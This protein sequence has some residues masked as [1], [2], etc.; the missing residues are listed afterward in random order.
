MRAKFQTQY[1]TYMSVYCRAQHIS[2]LF[3]SPPAEFAVVAGFFP[4]HFSAF[5]SFSSS[6][7]AFNHETLYPFDPIERKST[8]NCVSNSFTPLFVRSSCSILL[9]RWYD[10]RYLFETFSMTPVFQTA[11]SLFTLTQTQMCGCVC[12][13]CKGMRPLSVRLC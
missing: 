13:R 7:S 1:K 9:L 4:H 3:V 10:V 5:F 11:P 8:E 12:V 6:I 2:F